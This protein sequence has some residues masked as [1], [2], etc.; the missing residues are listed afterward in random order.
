MS[1]GWWVFLSFTLWLD[2]PNFFEIF[3]LSVPHVCFCP[4]KFWPRSL[5][6]PVFGHNLDFL[7][8]TPLFSWKQLLVDSLTRIWEI[9]WAQWSVILIGHVT[10]AARKPVLLIVPSQK[11]VWNCRGTDSDVGVLITYNRCHIWRLQRATKLL[12]EFLLEY[13]GCRQPDLF[14]QTKLLLKIGNNTQIEINSKILKNVNF[15]YLILFLKYLIL[16][17]TGWYSDYLTP[18]MYFIY[19]IEMLFSLVQVRIVYQSRTLLWQ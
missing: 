10:L 16:Y 1:F 3:P 15:D 2:W 4:T 19:M 12:F 17:F 5:T 13:F 8:T 9:S 6:G 11:S 7:E 14:K 18:N